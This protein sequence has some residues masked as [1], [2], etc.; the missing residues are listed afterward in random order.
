M[1]VWQVERV[2]QH[3]GA[4]GMYSRAGQVR[5]HPASCLAAHS[6]YGA[7]AHAEIDYK[8]RPGHMLLQQ[9]SS[10]ACCCLLRA[11]RVL[12]LQRLA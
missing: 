9:A 10:Q 8:P 2:G 5:Q 4:G 6:T 3:E 1:W 7:V 11:V 12:L